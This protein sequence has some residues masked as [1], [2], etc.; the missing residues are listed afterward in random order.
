MYPNGIS[1]KKGDVIT[2]QQA[3]ELFTAIISRFESSVTRLIRTDVTQNQYDALVSLCYN[4]G[5]GAFGGST[6]LQLLN[7]GLPSGIVAEQF[8]RWNKAGGK[9]VKGLTNRRKAEKELFLKP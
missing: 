6:L 5:I 2:Q 1:V 9:V 7:R 3:E 8:E 4:I